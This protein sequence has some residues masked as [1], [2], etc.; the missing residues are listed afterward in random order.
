LPTNQAALA[1]WSLEHAKSVI[2]DPTEEGW[3]SSWLAVLKKEAENGFHPQF[4]KYGYGD[5]TSYRLIGDV[6]AETLSCGAV[7]HGAECFNFYFPQELDPEFLVVWEGFP[8]KPWDYM[9]ERALK[10]FLIERAED[11]FLFPL[12]PVWPVRDIGWYEVLEVVRR[13]PA[14]AQAIKAWYPEDA[15][16]LRMIQDLHESHPNGFV[17]KGDA[18]PGSPGHHEHIS[19][20]ETADMFGTDV[21][22][23]EKYDAAMHHLGSIAKMQKAVQKVVLLNDLSHGAKSD[24]NNKHDQT[25]QNSYSSVPAAADA[26]K[27]PQQAITT[28][29]KDDKHGSKEPSKNAPASTTDNRNPF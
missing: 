11:G 28:D 15:G 1:K 8:D 13:Q 24:K 12:N 23:H 5:P 25:L 6:V 9:D 7:R 16:I 14:A 21:L 18:P 19:R 29:E 10:R 27:T 17:R 20:K 2:S 3:T 22:G 4:P 26:S